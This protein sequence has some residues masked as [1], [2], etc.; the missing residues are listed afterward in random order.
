MNAKNAFYG[1]I[2]IA[3]L[4]SSGSVQAQRLIT[5]SFES[6]QEFVDALNFSNATEIAVGE[7][8]WGNNDSGSPNAGD[9]EL[10]L[11]PGNTF[12]TDVQDNVA[13]DLAG[14]DYQLRFEPSATTS[15]FTTVELSAQTESVSFDYDMSA[16]D[17]LVLRVASGPMAIDDFFVDSGDDI[18]TIDVP[19]FEERYFLIENID[20]SMTTTING[21]ALFAGGFQ[22]SRPS[23]QF[24]F[25]GLPEG[26]DVLIPEPN[27]SL[28]ALG[29]IFAVLRRGRRN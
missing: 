19:S 27:M 4:L 16:A 7:A 18:E 23:F 9:I 11:R 1:C 17:L 2:A 8:R 22:G 24:K 25:I 3:C 10:L 26:T 14:F 28:L 20:P 29:A 15:G 21:S 6:D 5:A 12:Q 13:W